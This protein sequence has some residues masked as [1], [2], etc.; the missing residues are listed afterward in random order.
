MSVKMKSEGPPDED[1]VTE[2]DPPGIHE[3]TTG[4]FQ[5]CGDQE[6]KS[7]SRSPTQ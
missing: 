3:E 4:W 7:S 6:K 2:E 5:V 1:P